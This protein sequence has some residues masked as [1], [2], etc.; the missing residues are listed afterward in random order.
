MRFKIYVFMYMC[1]C[2]FDDSKI[3]ENEKEIFIFPLHILYASFFLRY[4]GVRNHLQYTWYRGLLQHTV[5]PNRV[6]R[7]LYVQ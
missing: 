3:H 1:L 7:R 6:N 4:P 2:F 5:L